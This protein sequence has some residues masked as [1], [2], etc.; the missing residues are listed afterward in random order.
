MG[1]CVHADYFLHDPRFAPAAGSTPVL[2]E[3]FLFRTTTYRERE[4]T[5][6][7]RHLGTRSLELVAVG[8]LLTQSPRCSHPKYWPPDNIDL[9]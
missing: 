3:M 1:T 4:G 5:R 6:V 9:K 7:K 2:Y 8:C